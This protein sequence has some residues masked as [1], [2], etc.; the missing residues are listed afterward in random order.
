MHDGGEKKNSCWIHFFFLSQMFVLKPDQT[1]Q[2]AR[3]RSHMT[4][5][6]EEGVSPHVNLSARRRSCQRIRDGGFT[7]SAITDPSRDY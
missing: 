3:G 5:E 7:L 2:S 1:N 6:D 4:A